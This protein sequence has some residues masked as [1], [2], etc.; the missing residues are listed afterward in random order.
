[1]ERL[2][3]AIDGPSG[4]GKSSLGKELAR[5]LGYLYIDSGAVYRA[6]G[7]KA[8]DSGVA[9]DDRESLA[10]I[11]RDADV[12]LE[13]DPDNLRVFLDGRDVTREIRL[14]DAS[15]ASSVVATVPEVREAVVEKLR[16]MSAR[17]GVVMDGRDIGTKVFPSADVKLFLEAAPEVRARRRWIEDRGRGRDVSLD[18]ISE[19][20]EERDRR[21]RG[22]AATPLVKAD[23]AILIDT[24]EMDF[25]RVVE[26]VLE[27][28]ESR[29]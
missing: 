22:R 18:Q 7:R 11:A 8:I 19:E 27:I 21:D 15:H 9:L 4:V 1:M 17:G 29:S 28:V 5:R 20:L 13:G 23:D 24:S 3:I 26:R 14:P 2:I 12:V 6:V 25:D 16:R 10:R